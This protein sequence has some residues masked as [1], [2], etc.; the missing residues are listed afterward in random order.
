MGADAAVRTRTYRGP[1]GG[2]RGAAGF[3]GCS[4]SIVDLLDDV[5]DIER[6]VARVSL[7]AGQPAGFGGDCRDV[8]RRCRRCSI[9]LRSLPAPKDVAP[10]LVELR[11]FCA[12]QAKYLAGAIKPDP[13][14]H[15]REGGVIESG[16]DAELDRL[17]QIAKSSQQWLAEYQAKLAGESGITSLKVGYNKVFGYYIEVTDSH[18]DKVPPAWIAQA[19]GQKR[20][21]VYHRGIEE[22]RDRGAGAQDRAIALEQQLFEQV[23]Q[24]LLPHVATF[25]ELAQ[26]VARVDVLASLAVLARERRYCRPTFTDDRMLEIVDGRHPV[27]E[28]QLGIE[29]VANDVKFAQR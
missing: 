28:Q 5:C 9:V 26:G 15:L 24:E 7:G 14:P 18:R 22:V 12:E 27:L 16:F 25:A 17:R 20:R 1:A 8:W 29:F 3:A 4:R 13:A 6:I 21:A 23:R 2:D 10:E 11:S 19:D